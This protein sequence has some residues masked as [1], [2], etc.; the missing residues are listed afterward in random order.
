MSRMPCIRRT[1]HTMTYYNYNSL[2]LTNTTHE[3]DTQALSK[4]VDLHLC[5]PEPEDEPVP[6][7]IGDGDNRDDGD[8]GDGDGD[9]NGADSTRARL[10]LWRVLLCCSEALVASRRRREEERGRDRECSLHEHPI[11]I[12]FRLIVR[13]MAVC[14]GPA[15]T[16]STLMKSPS[17]CALCEELEVDNNFYLDL[18]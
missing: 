9:G 18:V 4:L 17:L 12:D 5:A 15:L 16:A 11:I 10:H 8:D 13:C 6:E 3:Q 14:V 2:Q 1:Q 7:H